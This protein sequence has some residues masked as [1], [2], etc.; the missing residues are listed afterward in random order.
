MRQ[1]VQ[2]IS[3]VVVVSAV[4]AACGPLGSSSQVVSLSDIA[5]H[6]DEVPSGL[7]HCS[8]LSGAYP[9]I[10]HAFD[11]PNEDSHACNAAL[12]NSAMDAWVQ[13]SRRRAD[14]LIPH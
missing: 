4:L 6:P 1:Q 14:Y 7:T 3:L 8:A 11:H 12:T 13:S 5:L 10:A 2:A 9:A